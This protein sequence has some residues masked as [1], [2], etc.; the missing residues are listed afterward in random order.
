MKQMNAIKGLLVAAVLGTGA[1]ANAQT[2]P[3]AFGS[4]PYGGGASPTNWYADYV[5]LRFEVVSPAS[6]AGDKQYT[7]AYSGTSAWGAPV[8]APIVNVP[9]IMPQS[10]DSLA[11]TAVSVDM[12]GKIALVYRGTNY[13]S[14]KAA[15]CYAAGAIAVVIVNNQPGGPIGMSAATSFTGCP[16]FMISQADGTILDGLYY[17]HDTAHLTIT[18]WGQ[19]LT[20]D[21]GF[22]PSGYATSY[23]FATPYKQ[24][25]GATNPA[26]YKMVDGAFIGNFGVSSPTNVKVVG[27]LSFAPTG[28]SAT[29]QHSDS[30][31][32]A[33][34]FYGAT[35]T[36]NASY[37][38]ADSIMA[39]FSPSAYDLSCTG[40]GLYTLN[41]TVKGT[42]PSGSED[43]TGDNSISYS[44]YASDS[45]YSKG[46][47]DFTGN[48]PVRTLYEEFGGGTNPFTWGPMYY[49]AKGGS[50]ISDIQYSFANNGTT[51]PSPLT[52]ASGGND[53][54]VF[55]WVDGDTDGAGNVYPQ[56]GLVQLGELQLVSWSTYNF[57]SG[58]ADTSEGTLNLTSLDDATGATLTA[59]LMLDSNSY[60]YV[61]V[62]TPA[63]NFLGIDGV[64]NPYPRMYGRYHVDSTIEYSSIETAGDKDTIAANYMYAG[65]PT[66]G[67][68]TYLVNTVDSFNYGNVKGLIPAVAVVVR[69]TVITDTTVSHAGVK[70]VNK[71]NNYVQVYPVPTC[72]TLNVSVTLPATANSVT[73]TVID[74]AGRVISRETHNNVTTETF[75]INTTTYT[76]GNYYLLINGDGV[77]TSKK[78]VV[79]K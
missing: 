61:A 64:N 41:Y 71:A 57:G 29:V 76:S 37:G 74:A 62:E 20:N 43:F 38:T 54:Y 15:A 55:K 17:N 39:M 75:A 25:L 65:V 70:S 42:Y 16:V 78:F 60:Y 19:G 11:N 66:P 67:G 24:L 3:L 18:M 31:T 32:F 6:D 9:I 13:F 2:H 8:T 7:Y 68:Y 40:A 22:L 4:F 34:P 52:S 56:D 30:M 69:D 49:V 5:G 51:H 79:I 48:Q 33:G 36:S 45:V 50:A 44:F 47:Y 53:V 73:Y 12:T 46:R 35:D 1:V 26:A 59:P 58:A 23:N 77:R 28:S 63:G 21:I 10:G 14:D 27:S 72:E